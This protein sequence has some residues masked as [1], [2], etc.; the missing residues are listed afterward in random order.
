MEITIFGM[1]KGKTGS[2]QNGVN[3]N[4]LPPQFQYSLDYPHLNMT[5]VKNNKVIQ[6]DTIKLDNERMWIS[7][8]VPL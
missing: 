6:I 7:P 4:E 5:D 2:N 8:I 3:I 1:L